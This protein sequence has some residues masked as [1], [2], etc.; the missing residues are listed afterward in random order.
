MQKFSLREQDLENQKKLIIMSIYKL[1][2]TFKFDRT[3]FWN[4]RVWDNRDKE[5]K[6]L[7]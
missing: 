3:G 5:Y 4:I 7:R 6:S 2:Q 1:G